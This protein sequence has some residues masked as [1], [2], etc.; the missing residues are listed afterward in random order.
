LWD[1]G[2]V[3]KKGAETSKKI[4]KKSQWG[5]LL[6][7]LELKIVQGGWLGLREWNV[8]RLDSKRGAKIRG[9][10]GGANQIRR[11]MNLVRS[12]DIKDIQGQMGHTSQGGI[13]DGGKCETIRVEA[14]G[15]G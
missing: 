1:G 9:D 3:L 15:I 2:A 6:E 8:S 12:E 10:C 13:V 7:D 5:H 14:G 11:L 4:G